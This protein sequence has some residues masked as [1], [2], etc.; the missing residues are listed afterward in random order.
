MIGVRAA[1]IGT[2]SETALVQQAPLGIRKKPGH[3]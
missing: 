2:L 1:R 3:A